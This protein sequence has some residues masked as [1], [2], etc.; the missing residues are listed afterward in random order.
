MSHLPS[1]LLTHTL[2][3][4]PWGAAATEVLVAA[5]AAADPVAAVQRALRRDGATLFVGDQAYEL[6]GV[7]RVLLV[8][9]GK[10]AAAMATAAV[11]ALGE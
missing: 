1:T 10:A 6:A 7:R 11:A 4:A 2:R 3:T 9:V 8:A 5:L